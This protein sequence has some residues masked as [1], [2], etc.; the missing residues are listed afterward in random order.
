MFRKKC[1]V[2]KK[3]KP[4][5][6]LALYPFS[7]QLKFWFI[8]ESSN[9]K[10]SNAYVSCWYILNIQVQPRKH[11]FRNVYDQINSLIII[12]SKCSLFAFRSLF[13]FHNKQCFQLNVCQIWIV[14]S[15]TLIHAFKNLW[16][17][18]CSLFWYLI[19]IFTFNFMTLYLY[20]GI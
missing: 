17:Q 19:H 4:N 9:I 16:R 13:I 18:W 5:P 15:K 12:F 11:L 7:K 2:L 20:F 10:Q 8:N 1:Q 3:N 14:R 6:C